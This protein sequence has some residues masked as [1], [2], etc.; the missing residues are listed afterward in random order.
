MIKFIYF[1]F[2]FYIFTFPSLSQDIDKIRSERESLLKEIESS[3]ELLNTKISSREEVFKQVNLL[4]NQISSREN[5]IKNFNAEIDLLDSQI[6][7]NQLNINELEVSINSV[8]VEYVKLLQDS[9]LRRNSMDEL[10]FFLS[11]TDFSEAY[12]R[13][14]LLK[15]YANYRQQQGKIL[16][17]NQNQLKVLLQKS[18]SQREEKEQNL[19][20]L[21]KEKATLNTTQAQK[22]KLVVDLQNEEKWLKQSIAEKEKR[23][24]ALDNQILEYIRLS[25]SSTSTLGNDFKD[26]MGKMIWPVKKGIVVNHFGEHPHPVLKSVSIKNNGIDIQSADSDDVLAVHPG[27]ISRIISIPGYNNAIIIRHGKYLTVYANLKDIHVKQGQKVA[28]GAVL[29]KIYKESNETNG[30]LHF[31]I[32]EENQKLNPIKWLRP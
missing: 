28:M 24:Q 22:R 1:T 26:N 21:E 13:Y 31:E 10:L 23:A 6:E 7:L 16:I 12:R 8:K 2:L 9:Y 14:R 11:S 18:Q 5:L 25:K 20:K 19:Q 30:V 15:E 27:E 4:T 29:G 32:W 3:R 17:D